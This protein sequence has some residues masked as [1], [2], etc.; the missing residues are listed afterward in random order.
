[1]CVVFKCVLNSNSVF[2]P[3]SSLLKKR[4]INELLRW[5]LRT[6]RAS[7]TW[8]RAESIW[9]QR[10]DASTLSL[11]SS[12]DLLISCL[13]KGTRLGPQNFAACTAD[14]STTAQLLFPASGYPVLPTPHAQTGRDKQ[15]RWLLLFSAQ[16]LRRFRNAHLHL[17]HSQCV[18]TWLSEIQKLGNCHVQAGTLSLK[19]WDSGSART[20]ITKQSISIN[21]WRIGCDCLETIWMNAVFATPFAQGKHL[22]SVVGLMFLINVCCPVFEPLKPMRMSYFRGAPSM[23]HLPILSFGHHSSSA[24]DCQEPLYKGAK[25]KMFIIKNSTHYTR[26]VLGEAGVGP[27]NEHAWAS[28]N[29]YIRCNCSQYQWERGSLS[30]PLKKWKNT[31][32]RWPYAS[33]VQ[34]EI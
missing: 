4:W 29:W 12:V 1:M 14:G 3:K 10:L 31:F 23:V 33:C 9:K 18:S 2:T 17:S 8:L 26:A 13:R 32:D 6:I 30:W 20:K 27:W 11:S 21:V 28:W 25:N 24:F 22:C 16:L 15:K 34:N 7:I 5:I 19:D